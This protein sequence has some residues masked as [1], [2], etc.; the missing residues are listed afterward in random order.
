M[1][2][3]LNRE[4][5]GWD[6]ARSW[7]LALEETARDFHGTLPRAFCE[8]G[9]EHATV[10]WFRL[11]EEQYGIT[12]PKADTIQEAIENHIEVGVRAG[13]FRDASQFELT[14]VNPHR[15]ELKI[16]DC[17][18]RGPCETLLESGFTIRDLTCARIGC[19]RAS[20]EILSGTQCKYEVTGFRPD[21]IC[22]GYVEHR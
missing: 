20:A 16:V 21:G 1:V 4:N 7:L 12:V 2:Q 10:R 13:L 3:P 18:Y 15:V 9:Y 17:P 5:G 14:Q 19:F 22:E 6:I 8:R 11:L